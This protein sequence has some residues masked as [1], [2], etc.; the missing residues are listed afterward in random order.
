MPADYANS[1]DGMQEER[2]VLTA[3]EAAVLLG[4]T[5]E[6]VHRMAADGRLVKVSDPEALEKLPRRPGKTPQLL[7]DRQSV[8]GARERRLRRLS[9]D[10]GFPQ[11]FTTLAAMQELEQRNREL[12]AEV[13]KLREVIRLS[14]AH[15]EALEQAD[16]ARRQQLLQFVIPDFP[17]S[18]ARQ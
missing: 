2:G 7:V 11:D 8:M 16:R 15:D 17:D 13:M 6:T 3:P 14:L 1:T 12:M 9:V 10:N 5:P 18:E 4:V